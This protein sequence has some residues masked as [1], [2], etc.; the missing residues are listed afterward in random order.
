MLIHDQVTRSLVARYLATDI[1]AADELSGGDRA[2]VAASRLGKHFDQAPVREGGKVVGYA[3]THEL[4]A[5]PRRVVRNL[6]HPLSPA[7]IVSP[8]SP[9]R[10]VLAILHEHRFAFVEQDEQLVGFIVP[11]DMN[12][13]AGRVHFYMLVAALEIGLSKL[14]RDRST[15]DE[16]AAHLR[17]LSRDAKFTIECRFHADNR[18]GVDVDYVAYMDFT[19]LLKIVGNVPNLRTL[20]GFRGMKDWQEQTGG[21]PQLR[22]DVMHSTREFLSPERTVDDLVRYQDAIS[23]LLDHLQEVLRAPTSA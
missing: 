7:V 15:L 16:Q 18:M 13:Q 19:H 2:S 8:D 14:I 6:M 22:N 11:S 17:Y 10:E 23:A 3:L 1:D 5:S 12:K 9:I 20:L 4:K 21:L